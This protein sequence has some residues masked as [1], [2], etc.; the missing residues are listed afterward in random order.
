MKPKHQLI[1]RAAG[2]ENGITTVIASTDD[3]DRYSD[4]VAQ[5]WDLRS[6]ST[7]PVIVW[8]HDYTLPPV[9]K[10][11]DGEIKDGQLMARI[12]WDQSDDNPAGQRTGRQFAEGFLSAVSVGFA[13]GAS[14]QRTRLDEENPFHGKSGMV[15]GTPE[16]PNTLLE[17]SAVPL[18]AN[19]QA[20]AQRSADEEPPSGAVDVR[21]EVLRLLQ[22]D[23]QLRTEIAAMAAEWKE[24]LPAPLSWLA[25][26]D[27]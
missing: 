20:L 18:P 5:H 12:Q 2:T 3:V 4:V 8:A 15:Y 17:I 21:S 11:V 14:V 23:D 6:F 1:C 19:P 7:N 22:E 27:S 9:G 13:P 10:A 26:E 25:S 16:S 24:P